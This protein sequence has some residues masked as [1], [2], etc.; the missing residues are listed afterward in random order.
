MF[1]TFYYYKYI[2]NYLIKYNIDQ[3]VS[4]FDTDGNPTYETYARLDSKDVGTDGATGPSPYNSETEGAK[5]SFRPRNSLIF[6]L[7][8]EPVSQPENLRA[9]PQKLE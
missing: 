2:I 4:K 7:R 9:E 5:V 8:L 6:F 1:V 3:F